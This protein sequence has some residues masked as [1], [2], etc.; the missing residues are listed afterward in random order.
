MAKQSAPAEKSAYRG[1]GT[2][3]DLILDGCRSRG[4]PR[5]RVS[6]PIRFTIRGKWLTP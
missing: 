2:G 3:S 1:S 6:A 4:S 5:T